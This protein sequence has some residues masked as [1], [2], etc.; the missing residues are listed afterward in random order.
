MAP[1]EHE[2][3]GMEM[4]RNGKDQVMIQVNSVIGMDRVM[5]SSF[6]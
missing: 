1:L 6:P 2:R 4:A 5:R 3:E